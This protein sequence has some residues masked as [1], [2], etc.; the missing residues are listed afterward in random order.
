VTESAKYQLRAQLPTQLATGS[1][2]LWVHAGNG[3]QFGWSEPLEI[4]IVAPPKRRDRVIE[5]SGDDLQQTLDQLGQE[6]G[7]TVA[8]AKDA[9]RS[10]RHVRR[11]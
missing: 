2:Q 1:Y 3:G 8:F 9:N 10:A 5:F 4:D 11:W 6:G 7:G